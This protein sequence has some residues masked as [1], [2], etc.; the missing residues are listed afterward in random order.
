MAGL[1]LALRFVPYSD[2][3][4]NFD[5]LWT[6]VMIACA[7]AAFAASVYLVITLEIL[8]LRKRRLR[9]LLRDPPG[10]ARGGGCRRGRRAR[11]RDRELRRAV[12]PETG[13]FESGRRGPRTKPVAA[14]TNLLQAHSP[15]QRLSAI[16]VDPP[17]RMDLGGGCSSP[18]L[19]DLSNSYP[20]TAIV[21]PLLQLLR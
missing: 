19:G 5:P 6:A 15:G 9:E 4:G 8:K 3:H 13:E 18:S 10:T 14:V 7:L 17:R 11:A 2:D 20:A 16:V 21:W 12:D 1:A